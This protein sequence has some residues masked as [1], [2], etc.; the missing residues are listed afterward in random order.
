M[1]RYVIRF[2]RRAGVAALFIAAAILGITSGVVF[3]YAGD[4]P[5]ITALDDYAPSI[6]TRVYSRR[7]EVIGEF[8]TERR[9]VIGFDDMAPDLRNAILATEDAQFNSHFGLSM[10]RIVIAAVKDVAEG[11]VAQGASTLTQQLARNIASLGLNP[12]EKSIERKIREALLALQIEKRYTKREIFTLYCNQIYLGHGAHGVEAAARVYFDKRA[13]DLTLEEAAVIAAVIQAPSRLSPFVNMDRAKTRR[14]YVLNRMAVEEFVTRQEAEKAQQRPIVLRGQ[15]TESMS[16]APYF[17]EEV[18]KHLEA[19]YGAKALYESGLVVQSSLDADLQRVANRALDRGLRNLDRR[20]GFRTPEHNVLADGHDVES[21]AH[22]RWARPI[23]PDA[24]MPAVVLDTEGGSA[25]LRIGPYRAELTPEGFAWTRRTSAARLFEVGD[26]IEVRIGEINEPEL[27]ASVTLDQ[28]PI[29]EGALL[30]LDNRTGQVLAMVG[31]FSFERSKFNRATQAFRQLGSTFKAILY[32]AA[33]DR[34]YTPA[35]NLH[36]DPVTY[37]VGPDQ[38]PYK[39]TNYDLKFEGPITLRRALEKSRNVPAVRVMAELGPESVAEYARRFGFTS[40]L[41]PVLSLALGAGEAT[42]M[43]VTSAYSVFPNQGVRMR[44]YL[45]QK[46]TDREDNVLEENRPEATDAIRADTAFVM[47]NL[48]RGVV[49]RGT[50]ARASSIDWP[51]AGKTGTV[52][53]FTD[54]SFLGFD[55]DITVGVWVGHDE[56]VPL[57]PREE[58]ARVALPIWIEFMEAYIASR[59]ERPEF[60]PPGNIVFLSVDR[61]TGS[62][63]TPSSPSAL[64]EAFIAGTEPGVVFPR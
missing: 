55:P 61:Y 34:G 27:T 21:F 63:V 41:P 23:E 46:V 53:D 64:T 49:L 19:S 37:E 18:R 5:Q 24:V 25:R 57:G 44:P 12:R 43:E 35:T 48:L 16:I 2:A 59:E 62:V 15:P 13:R 32:S 26:L 3:A 56:K 31:G 36:D 33:I 4:L 1:A 40:P 30:A 8:A 52:D 50:A 9:S 22:E 42:L 60:S 39:P 58:G 54:A 17:V 28:T 7:G 6:I 10:S 38:P 29:V 11:R 51:L 47:T 45:V 20:R 14:D